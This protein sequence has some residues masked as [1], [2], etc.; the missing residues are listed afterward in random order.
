MSTTSELRLA[1]RRLTLIGSLGVAFLV[2][3]LAVARST[4]DGLDASTRQVFRPDD[5]WSTNQL[6][7]G[8]VVDGLA[9]PITAAILLMAGLTTASRR[10][11]LAPVRLTCGLV[12][13]AVGATIVSKAAIGRVDTH[14][15]LGT[16]G[17]AFPSGH[18]VMLVVSLGGCVLLLHAPSHWYHWVAVG[19]AAATMSTSLLVLATH[20]FTDV[21]GGALLGGLVV[22]MA[23]M[24][25]SRGLS[26][27]DSRP[28]TYRSAPDVP[29]HVEDHS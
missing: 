7:L 6:L 19:V 10:G 16:F 11:T 9:P 17:G 29:V 22:A 14:G 4:T 18:M 28:M 13:M 5:V 25:P 21:V 15:D 12:I 23:S 8:N 20:W 1:R 27:Y 24:A 2:L 3:C 26:G